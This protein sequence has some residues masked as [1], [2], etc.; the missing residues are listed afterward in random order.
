MAAYFAARPVFSEIIPWW[1]PRPGLMFFTFVPF[2]IAAI[3]GQD[4]ILSLLLYCLVWRQ[5]KSGNDRSAGCLA[6]L[7]LF[8]FHFAI[9][10]AL[11]L[12]L[13][14]GWRFSTGFLVTSALVVL[15]SI[16][17]IGHAGSAEYVHLL[18]SAASASTP[19]QQRLTIN[20]L[21]MPNLLGLLYTLGA[22]FIPS[23]AAFNALT[24]L[25]SIAIFAGCVHPVRRLQWDA[26]FAV[27]IL[28]GLLVSYHLY[29]DDLTLALLPAAILNNRI[30]KYVIASFFA[31]PI[32]LLPFGIGRAWFSLAALP[33][34]AM[35]VSALYFLLQ[36]AAPPQAE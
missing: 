33:V 18:S 22:R 8:K 23:P 9:P 2:L 17:L 27:A 35:L 6:G 36:S 10:I 7:A 1:Q 19:A 20:P 12:A 26:A 32:A 30:N 21:A 13:R 5:L 16:G 29:I 24:A 11:L 4:S 31:T 28:C 25:C 3:I 15:L 34:L 14:R